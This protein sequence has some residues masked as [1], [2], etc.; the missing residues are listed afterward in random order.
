MFNW[1]AAAKSHVEDDDLLSAETLSLPGRG[2]VEESESESALDSD[3]E[4]NPP[5]ELDEPSA[6]GGMDLRSMYWN[7]VHEEQVKLK[8]AHPEKSGREILKMARE[9]FLD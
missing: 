5:T 3:V 7:V 9:A 6:K 8:K 4:V 2:P 1:Q